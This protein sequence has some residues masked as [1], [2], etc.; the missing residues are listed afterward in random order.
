LK[1]K[2]S[3]LTISIAVIAFNLGVGVWIGLEKGQLWFEIKPH[4]AAAIGTG[5]DEV[6]QGEFNRNYPNLVHHFSTTQVLI[7]DEQ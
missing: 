5:K 7:A 3:I 6:S 4:A 1:P 2:G